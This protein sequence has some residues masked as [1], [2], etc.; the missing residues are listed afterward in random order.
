MNTT[1]LLIIED[2]Q[3]ELAEAFSKNGLQ[4]VLDK[5]RE[6]A[7]K[8]K[9]D[10]TTATGRSAIATNANNVAKSKTGLVKM[11]K[12]LV[13]DMK[14]RCKIIDAEGSRMENN[15]N[16]LKVE[17]R[18]PLT[19]WEEAEE[20]RVSAIKDS[21]KWMK[22]QVSTENCH[23]LASEALEA[24]K[25]DIESIKI[26][27][28]QNERNFGEFTDEAIKQK[29]ETMGRL[30]L[31]IAEAKK[32]E[33]D[34]I[35]L[36][37]LR[38]KDD[39][40]KAEDA[41][42]QAEQDKFNTAIVA[43]MASWI[44]KSSNLGAATSEEIK[45]ML[46]S[47]TGTVIDEAFGKWRQEAEKVLC[48][49]IQELEGG[50]T[51]AVE[52]ELKEKEEE[53]RKRIDGIQIR[54]SEIDDCGVIYNDENS[55]AGIRTR[56][57]A[58]DSFVIDDSYHPLEADAAKTKAEAGARLESA[59]KA[60]L[61][62]EEAEAETKRLAEEEKQAVID[63]AKA[64]ERERIQAKQDKAE[65][66]KLKREADAKH[67]RKYKEAASEAFQN[68]LGFSKDQG[69]GAVETIHSNLITNVT[70]NY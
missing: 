2:T 62:R 15:L 67:I 35:E 53:N 56:I 4:P 68:Q 27:D 7:M 44:K 11:R 42:L 20:V 57:T 26:I 70:I 30:T 36:E 51:I 6:E 5:I 58:L 55:P 47:A 60:A 19:D 38:N 3:I 28:T 18:K 33:A 65:Q 9:P 61:K 45:R 48:K 24:L 50:L 34:A 14:A 63:K 31:L 17:V 25:A 69:D 39:E 59:L 41:K 8:H 46:D 37:K 10:I 52:R 40:R 29:A 22:D 23:G 54:I 12:D 16:E 43:R 64:D 49:C 66:D 21:I 1:E 32:R 13:A